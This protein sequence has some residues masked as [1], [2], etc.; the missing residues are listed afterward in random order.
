[1]S[2]SPINQSLDYPNLY[3]YTVFIRNG[4][5]AW[6]GIDGETTVLTNGGIWGYAASTGQTG[7]VTPS[8]FTNTYAVD[9]N[10]E[11]SNLYNQIFPYGTSAPSGYSIVPFTGLTGTYTSDK[12][13]YYN[14]N[15]SLSSA[16]TLTFSNTNSSQQEFFII[17]NGNLS[18]SSL[19]TVLSGA[20]AFASNIYWVVN[21][22]FTTNPTNSTS[23]LNGNIITNLDF[24]STFAIID[25]NIFNNNTSTSANTDFISI[26]GLTSIT[27]ETNVCFLKGTKILTESGY[28]LIEDLEIGDKIIT[29]GEIMNDDSI[30]KNSDYYSEPVIWLGNFTPLQLNNSSYPICI[31]KNALGVNLPFED[32]YVSPLHRIIMYGKMIAAENLVNGETI[33]QD[34]TKNSLEYYHLEL[35]SH[36]CII[37]NGILT[38][39]YKDFDNRFVFERNQIPLK[40]EIKNPKLIL[41]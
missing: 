22:N 36:Y 4:S 23:T 6:G 13:Y 9:A 26:S 39:T 40:D 19:N 8:A 34:K 27:P 25:G 16:Q 38:E 31:K 7:T 12:I 35:P 24:T 5:L 10:N 2:N 41:A 21:G 17:V 14:G 15:L 29:K 30:N 1:M 11:L 20:Y 18:F 28:K 3:K 32:L 37:A 33:Y